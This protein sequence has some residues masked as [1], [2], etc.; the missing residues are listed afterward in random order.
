MIKFDSRPYSINDFWEWEQRK[1]LVL[2]P[3]FQRRSVWSDKARSYLIDTIIRGLPISKIF[4]RHDVDPKTRKS[5]REVVDGQ[6]RIRSILSYLNDGFKIS[7]THNE[8]LAKYYFSQ[9]PEEV[10]RDFLKYQISVDVLFGTEDA[11]VLDIFARLNTYTVRLNKQELLN[12]KFF[13]LFKSTV[14]SLGYEYLNFWTNNKILSNHEVT[15]MG[16]AELAS[17]LVIILLDGIQDR[18]RI[19]EYYRKYDDE[20]KERDEVVR[21]FK[22]AID[23]IS[24]ILGDN[25]PSSI[26]SSKP[27]FYSL[28]GVIQELIRD[29]KIRKKDYPKIALALE[30]IDNI[31]NAD[32]DELLPK[33][34]KFFDAA[35]KHVTDLSA[36]K[37]RH[38]FMKRRILEKI[39]I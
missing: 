30:N 11:L 13:G 16:E 33:D 24:E 18:K 15:R 37:I 17:E 9:L 32:P 22:A 2:A 3:K 20:F 10:Q 29:Q 21:K 35:T 19:D 34:F 36:R 23:T 31:L 1:E 4:M 27:L 38:E 39:K 14:Y 25:L 7:R 26:F 8:E 28:F 12:A 6:Q 5:I